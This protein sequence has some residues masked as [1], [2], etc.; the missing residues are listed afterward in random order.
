MDVTFFGR[1]AQ[2]FATW[3]SRNATPAWRQ[4]FK[5]WIKMIERLFRPS[6]NHALAAIQTPCPAAG[7]NVD[8][9]YAAFFQLQRAPHVIFVIRV[10]AVNN[11]VTR[12]KSLRQSCD[13]LLGWIAGRDHDPRGA[14]LSQ[15]GGKIIQGRRAGCALA[16]KGA[17]ILWT[18][19]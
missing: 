9:M 18:Q 3:S 19:V 8:V 16:R 17:H 4:R 7:T 15:F 10:A 12:F 11:D 6:V 13:G 14:G 1:A 2:F 5:D